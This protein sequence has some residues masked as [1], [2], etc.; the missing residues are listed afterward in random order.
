MF[1]LI[2]NISNDISLSMKRNSLAVHYL[3]QI[4]E[5]MAFLHS[6]QIIHRDLKP[7]NIVLS[8]GN[9]K[10]IDFGTCKILDE[11]VLP[12]EVV[13]K[14]KQLR[15]SGDDNSARPSFVGSCKYLAPES[16]AS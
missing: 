5:V 8:N 12:L 2:N 9:I 11:R 16:L 14:I 4:V 13:E 6:K 15:N 1:T 10:L 7:E 3:A